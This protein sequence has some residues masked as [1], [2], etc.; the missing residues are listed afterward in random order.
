MLDNLNLTHMNGRVYDPQLARF[1]SPDPLLG[2]LGDSQSV[3]PYAYV[4]NRPL[5]ATDPT[6]LFADAG[7]S[8]LIANYVLPSI[9][10]TLKLF[11]GGHDPLPPPPATALPGRSAQSGVGMCMPGT[12]APV[13]SG[14]VLYAASPG[15]G[16]AAAQTSTWG[17]TSVED[18]YARENI[19]QL[20]K[21]L[22]VN[23]VE[24]LI[25]SPVRDAQEAYE[26]AKRGDVASAVVHL[27]SAVCD[28]AKPCQGIKGPVKAVRKV[29]KATKNA[30][31]K[32]LA[33]VIPGRGNFPTLGPPTRSDVFVTAS[34]DIAGM[35]A[36]QIAKRLTVPKADEFTVIR[37]RTPSTGIATPINRPDPGFVG[38]GRTAGDA[39]EFVIPNGPIP[40]DAKITVVGK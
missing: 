12:Y 3:N 29:A 36:D 8:P 26:A 33:R 1:L 38:R 10:A 11:L 15:A 21:D 14:R 4:G 37:F 22:G 23:A 25:L 7:L 16:A 27:A 40:A 17:A 31:P 30:V 35:N 34:E 32:E 39:R 9:F 28:V 6:G 5:N 18:E 2:S 20:I 13:C 24:E 19:E